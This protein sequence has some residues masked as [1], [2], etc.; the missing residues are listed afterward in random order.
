[1][2]ALCDISKHSKDL[3]HT[4]VDAGGLPYLSNALSNPDVKLKVDWYN[5][6]TNLMRLF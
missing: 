6:S 3:A 1:M 5:L 2:S 4:I